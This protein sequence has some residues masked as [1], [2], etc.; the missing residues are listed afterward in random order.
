VQRERKRQK[1]KKSGEGRVARR[2]VVVFDIRFRD[3]I[4]ILPLVG[5]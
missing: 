5:R 3:E 2:A 4:K 1:K